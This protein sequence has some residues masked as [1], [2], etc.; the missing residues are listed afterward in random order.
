MINIMS[1]FCVLVIHWTCSPQNNYASESAK[2]RDF[3]ILIKTSSNIFCCDVFIVLI[4]NMN[5][6][7]SVM[8]WK[9]PMLC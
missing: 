8:H 6:L 1:G 9:P 5:C 7:L 2:S 3:C 4:Q